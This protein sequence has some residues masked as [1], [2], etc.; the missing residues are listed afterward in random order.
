MTL[1]R[2]V[3]FLV[4]FVVAGAFVATASLLYVT[5]QATL[6]SEVDARLSQ[7]GGLVA[8]DVQRRAQGR[9]PGRPGP[10]DARLFEDLFRSA[11]VTQFVDQTGSVLAVFPAGASLPVDDATLAVAGGAPA[12][13]PSTVRTDDGTYRML[14]FSPADGVAVQVARPIEEIEAALATMRLQILL[15]SLGAVGLAAVAGRLV[16]A[17]ILRPVEQLTATAELIATTQDLAHRIGVQGSDELARLG[18]AFDQMLQA[19]DDSR[20]AQHQLVADASHE[21]RTPLTSLRTNVE[22]L[23]QSGHQLGAEDQAALH[24]DIVGQVGELTALIGNL[25]EL[26]RDGADEVATVAVRLDELVAEVVQRHRRLSPTATIHLTASPTTVVGAPDRLRLAVANLVDNAVKY[27]GPGP[28]DVVVANGEVRVR[29]HGPGI[30]PEDIPHVFDR[31]WRAPRDR[32]APGSGLGLAIVAQVATAH[33]GTV[34]A[35]A[36]PDGVGTT[37]RL[38]LPPEAVDA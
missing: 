33:H 6:L 34:E 38:I 29:D 3:A 19:L 9:L 18:A 4:A 11:G 23:A 16:A 14:A 37:L 17:R 24:A 13:S 26:A 32:G 31:F 7:A 35:S 20:R 21:L 5:T 15:G 36:G 28:I 27:G 10:A 2:R 22:L 1:R 30:S 25:V 12:T 8:G